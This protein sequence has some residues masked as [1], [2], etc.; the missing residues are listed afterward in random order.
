MKCLVFSML[1]VFTFGASAETLRQVEPN[2]QVRY[3]KPALKAQGN[4]LYQVDPNGQVRYDKPSLKVDGASVN[5]H[6]TSD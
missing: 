2:G 4:K 3:D 6:T 1:L 5:K